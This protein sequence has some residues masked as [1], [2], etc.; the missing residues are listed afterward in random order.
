MKLVNFIA[1]AFKVMFWSLIWTVVLIV[2][3][4]VVLYSGLR[5]GYWDKNFFS[6]LT[7][8]ACES[9]REDIKAFGLS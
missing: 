3:G 9:F 4:V 5:Y 8:H 7:D 1:D 6:D 2:T